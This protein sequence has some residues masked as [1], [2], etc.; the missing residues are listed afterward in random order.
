MTVALIVVAAL[1]LLAVALWFAEREWRYRRNPA[2]KLDGE[3]IAALKLDTPCPWCGGFHLGLCGRVAR[4]EY[5]PGVDAGRRGVQR[6]DLRDR[7]DRRATT[8]PGDWLEE[9]R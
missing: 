3:D 2:P 9:P 1:I 7:W 6:V 4:I 5:Y 8:W